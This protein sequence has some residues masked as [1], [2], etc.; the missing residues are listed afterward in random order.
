MHAPSVL[1]RHSSCGVT[2]SA[3]S[4]YFTPGILLLPPLHGERKG[5][6][7]APYVLPICLT[8]RM[9]TGRHVSGAVEQCRFC[10]N[11][12]VALWPC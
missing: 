9:R 4:P 6:A 3:F 5:D 8:K 2:R 12:R 11:R 10:S 7:S 1:A